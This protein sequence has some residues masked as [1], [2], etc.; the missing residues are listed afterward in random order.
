MSTRKVRAFMN[1]VAATA[2]GIVGGL[3]GFAVLFG[4]S[5]YAG[6]L[7]VVILIL[8]VCVFSISA[9]WIKTRRDRYA[10]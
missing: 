3:L 10:R 1:E 8:A 2:L 6:W 9:N 5:L 4:L 7:P